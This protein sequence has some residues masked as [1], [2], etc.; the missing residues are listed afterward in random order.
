MHTR[1]QRTLKRKV[2]FSGIGIHTGKKVTL[3]F[4][5]AKEHTGIVFQRSDLP[6]EPI[7]PA[8]L[9]YVLDTSR[10]T[11]IGV[12]STHVHTVEHVLA[13]LAANQID[14]LIVRVSN[15][16]PPIGDGSS[17]PFIHLIEEAGIEEQDAVR[18]VVKI[19]RPVYLSKKNIH[20]I[21]LPSD[22]YRVSYTLNYPNVPVIRSQYFSFSVSDKGFKEEVS[23]CRTFALYEEISHLMDQGLIRGGSLDNAVVIK[24]NA[25]LSKEG[26]RYPDEMVRHKVLDL[27]GDLF[28]V[29][30]P[31]IAHIVAVCSGHETNVAFGKKLLEEGV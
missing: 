2:S 4:V 5:P 22:E 12:G 28:L 13:A 10:S 18:S 23:R 20:L 29:G 3:T 26:L 30:F 15:K 1:A 17:S 14:N 25:I 9:E 16:E 6:G 31:F 11:T 24:D 8:S 27:I 19:K 21:A 7:I